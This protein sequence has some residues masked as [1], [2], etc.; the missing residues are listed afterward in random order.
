MSFNNSASSA[1]RP[2]SNAG[3]LS[4]PEYQTSE[5]LFG[6]PGAMQHS[7]PQKETNRELGHAN[8][9]FRDQTFIPASYQGH[10]NFEGNQLRMNYRGGNNSPKAPSPDIMDLVNKLVGEPQGLNRV[11][12][13]DYDGMNRIEEKFNFNSLNKGGGLGGAI[14]TT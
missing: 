12:D 1:F 8:S 4:S 10:Q 5:D 9:N 3:G 14:R 13:H 2:I 7:R 11:Y 6:P